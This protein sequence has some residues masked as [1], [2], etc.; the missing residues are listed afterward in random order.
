MIDVK[1]ELKET[2]QPIFVHATNTYTKGPFYCVY[3]GKKVYK[4]PLNNLWR[5][6]EEYSAPIAA[7]DPSSYLEP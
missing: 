4:F 5:I 7:R 3:E 6:T 2:S 1:I